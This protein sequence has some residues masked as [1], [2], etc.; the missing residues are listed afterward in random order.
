MNSIITQDVRRFIIELELRFDQIDNVS[1]KSLKNFSYELKNEAFFNEWA[2]MEYSNL[3]IVSDVLKQIS[4]LMKNEKKI[5]TNTLKFL[6]KMTIFNNL[7]HLNVFEKENKNTKKSICVFLLSLF[8]TLQLRKDSIET[9][10]SEQETLELY[11]NCLKIKS[12]TLNHPKTNNKLNNNNNTI[13]I[14]TQTSHL[15]NLM[16]DMMKDLTS[17]E[18]NP[19]ELLQEFMKGPENF[20]NSPKMKNFTKKFE[21][22][23]E[24]KEF[25]Q[26]MENMIPKNLF[27]NNNN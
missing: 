17:G 14:P 16:A 3:Y 26:E 24:N 8:K 15:Q 20:Q 5:N 6:D 13:N 12:T 22:R 4:T 19:Q 11:D 25:Q 23:M 10:I 2:D 1:L 18:I 21:S 27:P 7:L 9:G